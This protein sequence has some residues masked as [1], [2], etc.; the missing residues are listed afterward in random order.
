MYSE[1]SFPRGGTFKRVKT[2]TES[3]SKEV[4]NFLSFISLLKLCSF[5]SLFL[6]KY[7]ARTDHLE[8]K[9][10]PS[11]KQRK[12]AKIKLNEEEPGEFTSKS[13]D[14]LNKHVILELLKKVYY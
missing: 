5:F 8:K 7:G 2:E 13:A 1:P 3:E 12:A 11:K 6:K 10:K 14:M 4:C 9:I